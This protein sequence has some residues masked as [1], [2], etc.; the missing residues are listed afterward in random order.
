MEIGVSLH[1]A[2]E[3]DTAEAEEEGDAGPMIH[4]NIALVPMAADED[5]EEKLLSSAQE[6]TSKPLDKLRMPGEGQSVD[7]AAK[8]SLVG[9][10]DGVV[11][12]KV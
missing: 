9:S 10:D 11:N 6:A 7:A 8:I 5:I 3:N 4:M 1:D 2:S 12:A